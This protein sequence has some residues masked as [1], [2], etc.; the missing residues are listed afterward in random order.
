MSQGPL[1]FAWLSSTYPSIEGL[2]KPKRWK[3]ARHTH[4]HIAN[5]SGA[6]GDFAEACGDCKGDFPVTNWKKMRQIEWTLYRV[7]VSIYIHIYIYIYAYIYIYFYFS[8]WD[9]T[10]PRD[11]AV[12]PVRIA[13]RTGWTGWKSWK[14]ILWYHRKPYCHMISQKIRKWCVLASILW[15]FH[16]P[17]AFLNPMIGFLFSFNALLED[18]YISGLISL[19]EVQISCSPQIC[20]RVL[21][22]SW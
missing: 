20:F 6:E 14:D 16:L 11:S 12:T 19:E 21:G 4:T 18:F 10:S 7:L 5:P 3:R 17:L 22:K 13:L 1:Y 15:P 8:P 9:R 2:P